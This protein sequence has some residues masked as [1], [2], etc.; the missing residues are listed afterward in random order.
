MTDKAKKLKVLQM[1]I[2]GSTETEICAKYGADAK[3]IIQES[4]TIQTLKRNEK[5]LN[6]QKRHTTWDC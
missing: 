4:K 3:D 5:L 1:Y 6:I 2:R